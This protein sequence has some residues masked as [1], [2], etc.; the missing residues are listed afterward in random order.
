[1][2]DRTVVESEE[3]TDSGAHP[4][5][6]MRWRLSLALIALLAGCAIAIGSLLILDRALLQ[7]RSSGWLLTCG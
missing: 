5:L 2:Q 3:R 7:K 6:R 4:G 1:M